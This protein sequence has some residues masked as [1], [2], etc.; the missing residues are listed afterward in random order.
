MTEVQD[1]GASTPKPERGGGAATGPQA[2]QGW[3][4]S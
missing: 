4:L 3:H 1:D 2:G